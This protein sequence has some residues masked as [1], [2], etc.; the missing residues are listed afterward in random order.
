MRA[1]YEKTAIRLNFQKI[2]VH[3]DKPPNVPL[4]MRPMQKEAFE[5]LGGY[6]NVRLLAPTGSGKSLAIKYISTFEQESGDVRKTII[7]VP[8][9]I[10][11]NSYR[12][13]VLEYPDGSKRR[14]KV[15]PRDFLTN[16]DSL[17][18]G[19]SH[20]FLNFLRSPLRSRTN[21]ICSYSSFLKALDKLT[22]REARELLKDTRVWVDECHHLSSKTNG[23]W[24][25]FN[26]LAGKI[27]WLMK[28][29]KNC[30]IGLTTATY[31]RGDLA[32]ILPDEV[33][34]EFEK[35]EYPYDRFF[36]SMANL[37][38]LEYKFAMYARK[39][40][41]YAPAET[42]AEIH[43]KKS[44]KTII[45]IPH[46]NSRCSH[47]KHYEVQEIL[48][49][50]GRDENGE[51]EFQES[52]EG[53]ITVV[54]E[55]G[56]S[57]RVL[58]LV[59]EGN[60]K[61]KK[62]YV[63]AVELPEDL[64]IVIALS[65]FKEGADWVYAERSVII[66]YKNSLN[67]VMQTIGRL[68]RDVDGKKGI[69]ICHL[70]EGLAD[71]ESDGFEERLNLFMI[72]LFGA[73]LLENVFAPIRIGP[74]SEGNGNPGEKHDYLAE[75]VPADKRQD[76]LA[77]VFQEIASSCKSFED[78]DEPQKFYEEE[79]PEMVEDLL[80]AG[81]HDTEHSE[82][83][84]EQIWRMFTRRSLSVKGL[85]VGDVDLTLV[86]RTNPLTAIFGFVTD[87]QDVKSFE[88][89]RRAFDKARFLSFEEAHKFVMS[90]GFKTTTDW[91]RYCKS[92]KRPKNIPLDPSETYKGKGWID[93]S[94]WL[95][96]KAKE[97]FLPF[98]EAHRFVM[99]LGFKIRDEW[100]RYCKSGKKPKNIP[101]NPNKA[102]KGKGWIDSSHWLTGK[103]KVK[104]LPFEE[105]HRFVM[106]LG[107]KTPA[108]WKRYCKS[109]KKPKNIPSNPNKAYKGKGWKGL[110]HWLTGKTKEKFL[111][112][113]EA[114]RFVMSLGFKTP[115]E[116][117]R[118]CKS[119]RRPE[120]IPSNPNQAY[121]DK[122]WIDYTH[123]LTGKAK[124]KFLPFEKAHKFVMSLG[125]K[126]RAEWKRYCK[127]G[128]KP[129]NIPSNPN[130]TYKDKG[131]I[132][133][134]HW[135]TGKAKERGR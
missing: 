79:Y 73:M 95:T 56:K 45:H 88:E 92:G 100:K 103:A 59:D 117:K 134:S 13:A 131:W 20:G 8:Q 47:G 57:L 39:E 17:T 135:L 2:D 72:A 87:K 114:H 101:S 41:K 6:S 67:E 38:T 48:K 53:L 58:N 91:K 63:E 28:E 68:T 76:F 27:I 81:G 37:E 54:D 130:R 62:R 64:D 112:F 55:H 3:V 69:E 24:T 108:E 60:R 89:I 44:A 32:E 99:S 36:A 66:G 104:F 126:I 120:N 80:Q 132:D 107:F 40:G 75:A 125:F 5:A 4:E 85:D 105:A 106:S 119:G 78:G 7:L 83:V 98:E 123:W 34:K 30:R 118:Y 29:V 50:L 35:Y 14:W 26:Q 124:E 65:M 33:A 19:K 94:Y 84:A 12:N 115:A 1:S 52:E 18:S 22:K 51:T 127:S 70:L 42:V 128:K 21:L 74:P 25:E 23:A 116:W 15:G 46:V 11:G 9:T 77:K 61:A 129:E 86:K 102:Y 111:P 109:G 10:I 31:Y 113:E 90:L 82:L 97:K 71:S 122:G 16:P 121:E 93:W 133:T 110:R 49:A 43:R 96:G